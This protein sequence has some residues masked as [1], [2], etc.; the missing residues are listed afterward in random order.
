[1][2]LIILIFINLVTPMNSTA[3]LSTAPE[4]TVNRFT[5]SGFESII[6]E[7]ANE[8]Q[9]ITVEVENTGNEYLKDIVVSCEIFHDPGLTSLAADL[10]QNQTVSLEVGEIMEFEFWSWTPFVADPMIATSFWVNI[11]A[12]GIGFKDVMNIDVYPTT[13]VVI[14]EMTIIDWVPN[15][16]YD[17]MGT[18][19]TP[20]PYV[21]EMMPNVETYNYSGAVH[22]AQFNIINLGNVEATNVVVEVD[23]YDI[24]SATPW[25]SV[26]NDQETVVSL[27]PWMPLG[28]TDF[29]TNTWDLTT[30]VAD[31]Q[32]N[33]TISSGA[34]YLPANTTHY[35]EVADFYDVKP[36]MLT[37]DLVEQY[38]TFTF[39]TTATHDFRVM[40]V[41]NG[42][43]QIDTD[44]WAR[45]NATNWTGQGP[46]GWEYDFGYQMI[47]GATTNLNPGD[48]SAEVWAGIAPPGV[49][50]YQF[51]VTSPGK[52]P[53]NL[54]GPEQNTNNNMTSILLTFQDTEGLSLVL[55]TPSDDSKWPVMNLPIKVAVT[56]TGTLDF[57]DLGGCEVSLMIYDNN[58]T[59]AD[60][61]DDILLWYPANVTIPGLGMTMTDSTSAKWTW[62]GAEGGK[63]YL[64]VVN[65]T[66]GTTIVGQGVTIT[67][68]HP[69]GTVSG[70]ITTP[71]NTAG[72]EIKAWEGATEILMTTTD[73][74]GYYE[75][76]LEALPTAY[77]ITV[78][79][80]YGYLDAY[81]NTVIVKDD[82][83]I[84]IVNFYLG[85][86]PVGDVNGTI[87]LVEV[88]MPATPAVD[89]TDIVVA[90]EGTPL[91]VNA[92]AD[93]N[94]SLPQI[95]PN[96]VNVTATM[97]GF[98]SAWNDSVNVYAGEVTEN[99]NFILTEDWD[100]MV[101]PAHESNMVAVDM[102]IT[103]TFEEEINIT[104]VNLTNTFE[105]EDSTGTTVVGVIE[106]ATGNM[107]FTFIPDA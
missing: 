51:N 94:Y 85:W 76:S 16:I 95:V 48:A 55:N 40:I 37:T 8:T 2:F 53:T 72:I 83:R 10:G 39:N 22:T 93:G 91:W 67:F 68:P 32:L 34:D 97:L 15:L 63:E 3:Q 84:T 49:G 56:N 77:N 36:M 4:I 21:E 96:I 31:G 38:N 58:E 54:P 62:T 44:F 88:G 70:M 98:T 11:T 74:T 43:Q 17:T 47:D 69:N 6:G 64:V 104:S 18:I 79:A 52:D 7:Y 41:N 60:T 82:L 30:L 65:A 13:E 46:V 100:V 24:S 80:P 87:T 27:M 90:V 99:V 66:V 107:S 57:A 59:M 5:L 101:D 71:A 26:F 23:G 50:I 14:R 102:V 89:Y 73:A 103:V 12:A 9:V 92:D 42:N 106:W 25:V 45:L 35:F 75:M 81:N 61:S 19:M 20:R 105:V 86:P 29:S 1:M 33:L 78:T 28:W